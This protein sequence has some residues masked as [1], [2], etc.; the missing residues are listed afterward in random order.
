MP[1]QMGALCFLR[2]PRATCAYRE[3][4]AIAPHHPAGHNALFALAR[5]LERYTD[6]R[7][8]AGSVYRDYVE[9]APKR[10]LAGQAREALCRLGDASTC[11]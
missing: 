9:R 6:D 5:L 7:S 10:A 11:Q 2:S 8:A 3:A 4:V 1:E